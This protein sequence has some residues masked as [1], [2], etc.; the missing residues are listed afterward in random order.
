[1]GRRR[2]AGLPK[3]GAE[4]EIVERRAFGVTNQMLVRL[5]RQSPRLG[6]V[7]QETLGGV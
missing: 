2:T 5:L 3:R 1:M 6:R 7:E 4:V